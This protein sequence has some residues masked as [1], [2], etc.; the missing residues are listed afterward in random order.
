MGWVYKAGMPVS[1]PLPERD[2]DRLGIDAA[3]RRAG[4]GPGDLVRIGAVE[5][6]WEGDAWESDE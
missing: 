6:V 5:L 1:R 3:L 2:L 4:I